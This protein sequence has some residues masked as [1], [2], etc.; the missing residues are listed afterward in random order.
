M[1][2]CFAKLRKKLILWTLTE[3]F[4]EQGEL[5][6]SC[7]NSLTLQEISSLS[8]IRNRYNKKPVFSFSIE[9]ALALIDRAYESMGRRYRNR[10]NT[11]TIKF[12][13]CSGELDGV[14]LMI[15]DAL[16]TYD[17]S[18][19]FHLTPTDAKESHKHHKKNT[20][21]ARKKL[22]TSFTDIISVI[23]GM[24][25]SAWSRYNNEKL[26]SSLK[27]VNEIQSLLSEQIGLIDFEKRSDSRAESFVNG[28][29][30]HLVWNANIRPTKPMTDSHEKTPLLRFLEVFYPIEAK[31]ILSK[32]YDRERGL[33]LHE[34]IGATFITPI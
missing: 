12:G 21:H 32:I 11:G 31:A 6:N 30:M 20:S 14:S 1:A 23:N 28:V 24:L 3:A 2:Y 26:R 18:T 17:F 9:E 8:K 34:K 10:I 33:P 13:R 16:R 4:M 19:H 22:D 25:P 27:A 29:C 15:S 5:S 7:Y